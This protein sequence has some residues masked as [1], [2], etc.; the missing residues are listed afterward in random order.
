VV[1]VH[2][3]LSPETTGLI[4]AA[5]L[6]LMKPTAYLVNTS[7]GQVVRQDDLVS[8]LRSRLIAGAAL[9]AYDEEPLAPG[10]PFL[11]LDELVLAPHVGYVTHDVYEEFFTE[12]VRSCAAYLNGRPI[13]PLGASGESTAPA[14]RRYEDTRALI[15]GRVPASVNYR[16]DSSAIA[17]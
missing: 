4:D 13:R 3:V 9:D 10:H 12:T 14:T 7:R 6:S 16:V 1:T 5:A 8:A 17:V 11:D 15:A 2:T